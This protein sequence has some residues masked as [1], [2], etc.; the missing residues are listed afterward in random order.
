MLPRAD[1]AGL[2]GADSGIR[3]ADP[4]I[5][6]ADPRSGTPAEEDIVQSQDVTWSG[7]A[8]L[9][10][11][12]TE[13]E[14]IAEILRAAMAEGRLS[15]DEGGERLATAYAA[16]F[17]DELDVL[18]RDLPHGGRPALARM[19]H[20]RAATRR[21]LQRHASFVLIAAGLLI[22]LWVLSGAH[23]FWPAL[24]LFFLVTGWFRH[25]RWGRYQFHHGMRTHA[26]P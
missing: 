2:P 12:D 18:T 8:R 19:P 21:S 14:E 16:T 26:R 3:K 17:R 6:R 4:D 24:P 11:S 9:R 15:L 10:T 22:T 20:R 13:R 25:V 23:F 1:A 5:R 7:P